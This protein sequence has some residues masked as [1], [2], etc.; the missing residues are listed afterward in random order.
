MTLQQYRSYKIVLAV[1]LSV[2]FSQ[3]IIFKNY[4]I[5]IALMIAGSLLLMLLRRR[6]TEI[7]ADERD[8]AIGGKSA[9]FAIQIYGW[10][11]AVSMFV[12]YA[13]RDRN[14]AYEP[15]GL[16]LAFSTCLLMLL[17]SFIFRYHNRVS[18]SDKKSGFFVLAVIIS[19]F[20]AIFGIRLF[21]GEDDWICKEGKWV[22]HGN[23]SF[24]APTGECK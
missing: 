9:M 7:V 22:K 11:A 4:L 15:I 24:P 6:V 19:V 18:T 3:A 8:Y 13:L 23:P 16:T 21:S 5:P 2:I 17:Y 1:I 20:L 10:L 12:F 14:P